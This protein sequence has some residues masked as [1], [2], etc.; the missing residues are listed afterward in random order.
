MKLSKEQTTKAL[1]FL[2]SAWP[3]PKEC[4]VC[5]NTTWN[6]LE[7]IFELREANTPDNDAD[8]D[9]AIPLVAIMCKTCGNTIFFNALATGILS[10]ETS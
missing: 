2:E 10:E 7:M 3:D 4:P 5:R 1:E 6:L 8:Q 9:S